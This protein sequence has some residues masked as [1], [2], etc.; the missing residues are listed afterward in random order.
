MH[1]RKYD[2]YFNALIYLTTSVSVLLMQIFLLPAGKGH[3]AGLQHGFGRYEKI[4]P[5]ATG[6][7][8]PGVENR[9]IYRHGHPVDPYQAKRRRAISDAAEYKSHVHKRNIKNLFCCRVTYYFRG[10]GFILPCSAGLSLSSFRPTGKPKRKSLLQQ[11][12]QF[13]GGRRH[14]AF[15][16]SG[17]NI[18]DTVALQTPER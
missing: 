1:N 7:L 16:P 13:K 2:G 11:P 4:L 5:G 14:E 3:E 15:N 6:A 10:N 17:P 12:G 9:R 18:G 8:T